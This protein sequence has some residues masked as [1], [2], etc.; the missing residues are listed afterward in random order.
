MTDNGVHGDHHDDHDDGD[1]DAG[2][3]P[4]RGR[5]LIVNFE[6]KGNSVPPEINKSGRPCVVVHNNGLRRGRLV[7]VVP[8]STTPPHRVMPYHHEMD[9]RSFRDWPIEGRTDGPRW[10]KCDYITTV[11]LTRC[12]DPS[13]R[14][15]YEKRRHVKVRAIK[16]DM[17]AIDQCV[18][19]A[20]GIKLEE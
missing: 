1:E 20:L 4:N 10:A 12:K 2:E 19:W 13:Y 6:L 11:S 9:H 15:A 3:I 5:I 18:L 14:R 16:A 8:L 7:T 17:E